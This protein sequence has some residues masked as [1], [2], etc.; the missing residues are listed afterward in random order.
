MEWV[1][2]YL[3]NRKQ[4][5]VYN[6]AKSYMGKV[7]IGV[8]QGSILGPLLFLLYVNDLSNVSMKLSFIQFAD[9]TSIF[10]KGG[11][12]SEIA[13]SMNSEMKNVTEWLRN[14]MLTLN[15]TKTNYMIMTTQGKRYNNDECKIII[16]ES[17]IDCVSNTKFLGIMLDDKLSWKLHINHICNK[18]SKAIGILV[19]ARRILG[20]DSLVT[21]YNTLIKPYFSYCITLWGNTYKTHLKKLEILQK[22]IV[23]ILSFSDYNAHTSPL[24]RRL[25]LMTLNEMYKYFSGIHIYKCINHLLPQLFWDEFMLSKT[26]RNAHNL[27]SIF[28]TKK[29]CGT[30]LHYSGP[31]IWNEFPAHI[32]C[33]K[34]VNSFKYNIKKFLLNAPI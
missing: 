30:S 6:N 20:I 26:L 8:P 12:L 11:S 33:A 32:K 7:N 5:V 1:R 22:K 19:K 14:N 21:L 17:I 23:R 29:I 4:F 25:N 28:H 3:C 34:S 13:L 31:K 18:V 15:V 9:D 16:D 27:Q 2:D 24:F 10:I